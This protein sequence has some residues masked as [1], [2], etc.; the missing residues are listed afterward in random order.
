MTPHPSERNVTLPV[1]FIDWERTNG[2]VCKTRQFPLSISVMGQ[3]F[4]RC[5]VNC[6]PY[7]FP[8]TEMLNETQAPWKTRQS[9]RKLAHAFLTPRVHS[10]TWWNTFSA[11]RNCVRGTQLLVTQVFVFYSFQK[12]WHCYLIHNT[13]HI[14]GT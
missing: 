10:L 7:C 6:S 13:P 1:N 2:L 11:Y 8:F 3:D 4:Q 14:S 9:C 5:P 12:S